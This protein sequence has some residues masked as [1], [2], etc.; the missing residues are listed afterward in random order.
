MWLVNAGSVHNI[1]SDKYFSSIQAAIN[2][3]STLDGHI[4]VT[5][6]GT[7]NENVVINKSIS[8]MGMGWDT[9]VINGGGGGDVIYISASWVNVPGFSIS[10]GG[11]V[12]GYAGIEFDNVQYCRAYDNHISFNDCYG[13][14][15]NDADRNIISANN[16]SGN[17]IGVCLRQSNANTITGNDVGTNDNEGVLLDLSHGNNV[18]KNMVHHNLYD[19]ICLSTSDG[20]NIVANTVSS[21]TWYG[22]FVW[23]DSDGNLVASN[24]V[25]NNE[26]GI[27]LFE[28]CNDNIVFD[29]TISEND[30]G[31][32]ILDSNSINNK[33]HHNNIIENMAQ[34][35]DET[36]GGNQWD[37]GYPSGGNFWSDYT[38][39]DLKHGPG[40][41]LPG[42]D[43]IG[44]T[45]Y[46]VGSDH[47]TIE[48]RR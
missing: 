11:A 28:Y 4:I 39:V 18:T 40:Q 36:G 21:N 23:D 9:P 17:Y 41:N 43:S 29:N 44:D 3:P 38:G 14:Y 45:P 20:N 37:D 30:W 24:I 7:Y 1:N 15:L 46:G 27:L 35:K 26:H 12:T 13:I 47:D 33:I 31:I 25:S 6:S 8:L 48:S 19:G 42:S 10:G 34:A 2:D 5:R 32:D 22:I 16:A